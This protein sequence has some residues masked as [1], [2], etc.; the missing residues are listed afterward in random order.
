MPRMI[1]WPLAA[2]QRVLTLIGG[3][4][5]SSTTGGPVT[6]IRLSDRSQNH[7][8]AVRHLRSAGLQMTLPGVHQLNRPDGPGAD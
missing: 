3:G 2:G 5:Q 6:N 1:E 7:G 8:V 4:E